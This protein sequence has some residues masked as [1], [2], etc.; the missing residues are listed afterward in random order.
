MPSRAPRRAT[1][2][3]A[4]AAVTTTALAVTVGACILPPLS[5]QAAAV[6]GQGE[7]ASE[8]RTT[9]SFSHISIGAGVHVVVR[10]GAETSVTLVAQQNL[11]P[12]ITTDVQDD[13][14]VVE[15]LPPGIS[16]TEPVTLTI[17]T[18][19]LA[20]LTLSAGATGTLEVVGASLAVDV[21]AGSTLTAIG[22]L[23]TLKLTASSAAVAKLG[24]ITA[25]SAAVALTG[26][27][28][29][30]LHVTGAVTGTA[31]AGSTLTLTQKP[32]SVDVKTS[33]GAS[34]QGG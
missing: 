32:A 27:S 6:Q 25:G 28:A 9:T 14:L 1:L 15:V 34:V 19:E 26:G 16:S 20:S 11:L 13:Q 23:D 18:P 4:V 2:L 7:V 31:D 12:L 21:S 5:S 17:H 30:E 22:K 33:G 3:L 10:T 8:D 24:E 29:A